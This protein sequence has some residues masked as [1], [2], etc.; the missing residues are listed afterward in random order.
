MASSGS[1]HPRKTSIF[2]WWCSPFATVPPGV[3]K[4]AISWEWDMGFEPV[5]L[6]DLWDPRILPRQPPRTEFCGSLHQRLCVCFLQLDKS[7]GDGIQLSRLPHS[8]ESDRSGLKFLSDTLYVWPTGSY[9]TGTKPRALFREDGDERQNW[10]KGQNHQGWHALNAKSKLTT[11][12]INLS[13][14]EHV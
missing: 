7:P 13:V 12:I 4:L 8:L 2:V 6:P 5:S 10:D 11:A 1:R 14:N 9:L 3:P